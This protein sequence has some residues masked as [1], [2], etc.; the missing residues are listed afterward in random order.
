LPSRTRSS[1]EP[2]PRCDRVQLFV[3]DTLIHHL[4]LDRKLEGT[5][6]LGEARTAPRYELFTVHDAYPAMLTDVDRGIRVAGGLYEVDLAVL[7]GLLG[8]GPPLG[9]GL[10]ELDSGRLVLGLVWRGSEPPGR[11]ANDSDP[12]D[13]Q[14]HVVKA[15]EPLADPAVERRDRPAWGQV[16]VTAWGHTSLAVSDLDRAIDFYRAAFGYEPVFIER[17]M[18]DQIESIVGAVGLRCDLAQ[19]RSPAS[20]HVLELIAFVSPDQVEVRGPVRPGQAHV[21]FTV[22]DLA[23]AIERMRALGAEP[24][25]SVTQFEEGRAVYLTEPSG[26]II[27]LS[28]SAAD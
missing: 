13:G 2:H 28:E 10:V 20:G 16:Q 26:T 17:G 27:E 23:G 11:S 18:S 15:S 4:K 14:T 24:I 7:H 21:A 19:L 6:F 1:G 22:A 12:V 8:E 25:G 3:H 5:A 9:V